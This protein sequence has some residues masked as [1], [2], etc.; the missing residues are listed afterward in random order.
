[1]L[2]ALGFTT[3]AAILLLLITSRVAAV[4]ALIG[5]P[6]LA[7]LLAGHGPAEIGEMI[8]SGIGDIVGV[9]AM[10]VF[11]ILFFGVLRDAGMFDPIVRRIL[12]YAGSNP[13]T[14]AVGTALL[15][16]VCHLDGAGAT[17]FV[18]TLSALLPLYDAMGMSRLVLATVTGLAAGTMNMLPW[19]G[20]TARASS[21][22]NV[23]ANALWTPLLPAQL[24]GIAAV[25]GAAA[26]LGRREKL[27]LT[28]GAESTLR[29]S[30]GD[31]LRAAT[32]SDAAAGTAARSADD[33]AGVAVLEESATATASSDA[34]LTRPR[35][36]WPNLVLT[37]MT[38]G[39]L[40]S[41]IAP[42]AAVFMVA[43][44][45]ALVVNYPGMRRQNARID[46]H[47]Q[48]AV[49]MATTLLAA[50]AF[51]GIM[52]GT[53]MIRAMAAALAGGVPPQL[54]PLLPLLVGVLAV[55]MSFLFGP[56][57]Y[58][59]GVLPVLIG[60][61]E[62]FGIAPED[63]AQ[64]SIL[65]EETVGF[66]LTPMTG[67]FFLLVGLARVDIGRHIRHMA[68]WAWGISLLALAVA[69]V[70]GVVPVWAG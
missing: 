45:L 18:I 48:S 20:P 6:V 66:P 7:A 51:L 40:I 52:G 70:T 15:A 56:D 33:R 65:G 41:G 28:T 50:G 55:P 62:Q 24:T 5:V 22:V 14:I 59:F 31:R 58:Y 26:W 57:P 37:A 38:V 44:V 49:L 60:V 47:A 1:M 43:L 13:V 21:V 39:V 32:V 68:P 9:V 19:A 46:A 61:G 23:D 17:T 11:A 8:S 64:A 2:T 34:Q 67:A 54:G 4:A 10:F 63:L 25:L 16:L 30:R 3:I 12:Q 53:G 36:F 27:R 29:L 42:P 69:V 35:L